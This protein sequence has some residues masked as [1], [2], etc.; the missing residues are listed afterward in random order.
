MWLAAVALTTLF[1][2]WLLVPESGWRG[3]LLLACAAVPVLVGALVVALRIVA[4]QPAE[5]HVRQLVSRR[6]GT[7]VRSAVPH[8]EEV[9]SRLSGNG[10]GYL[11]MFLAGYTAISAV[12]TFVALGVGAPTDDEQIAA[13]KE[14]GVETRWLPTTSVK[15]VVEDRHRTGTAYDATITV[16]PPWIG[17]PDGAS[18][19]SSFR[20]EFGSPPEVGQKVYVAF[21]PE[22]PDLGVLGDNETKFLD[23]KLEARALSIGWSWALGLAW[24]AG[25]GLLTVVAFTDGGLHRAKRLRGD[26]RFVRAQLVGHGRRDEEGEHVT[27]RTD[28]GDVALFGTV[29]PRQLVVAAHA[30]EGWLVWHPERSRRRTKGSTQRLA[31]NFIADAPRWQISGELTEADIELAS[32]ASSAGLRVDGAGAAK[33]LVPSRGWMMVGPTWMAVVVVLCG[34]TASVM[35]WLPLPGWRLAFGIAAP[36]ALIASFI[37]LSVRNGRSSESQSE[38]AAAG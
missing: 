13:M 5:H 20:A 36:V 38:T 8:G 34:V 32:T 14:S 3:P 2:V 6:T 4:G 21:A 17:S 10:G 1:W 18:A 30:Q 23:R 26:E 19:T 7:G 28:A 11:R 9:P 16:Q 15:D 12:V 24:I 37:T 27:L 33:E 35:V 31:V 25:V 29:S 22:R